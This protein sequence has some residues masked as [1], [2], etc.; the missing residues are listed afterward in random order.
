[1]SVLTFQK[2][3]MDDALA[4]GQKHLRQKEQNRIAKIRRERR[5]KNKTSK[6]SRQRNR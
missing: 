3:M 5:K 6:K 4:Q 1:M 2:Q